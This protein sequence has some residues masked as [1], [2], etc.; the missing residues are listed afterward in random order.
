M[1]LLRETSEYAYYRDRLMGVSRFV[2]KN[3]D[4]VAP[5]DTG[6]DS[7]EMCEAVTSMTDE[8]FNANGD[9]AFGL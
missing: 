7:V 5:W 6:S 9:V 1:D 8:C 2:R 4:D 3:S